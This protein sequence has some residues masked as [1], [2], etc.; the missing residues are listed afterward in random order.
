MDEVKAKEFVNDWLWRS[1]KRITNGLPWLYEY[2]A[3]VSLMIVDATE[4]LH[5][6]LTVIKTQLSAAKDRI[7]DLEE[8]L[9]KEVDEAEI[10]EK[11]L[12]EAEGWLRQFNTCLS[13]QD[14]TKLLSAVHKFLITKPA[15]E[16]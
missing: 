8:A 12:S 7:I 13:L 4:P 6:K 16:K 2:K 9:K 5:T 15:W 3:D 11:R 14:M 1:P 10:T